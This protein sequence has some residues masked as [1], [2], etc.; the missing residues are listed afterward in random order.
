I[1]KGTFGEVYRVIRARDGK[2]S[3]AKTFIRPA[4]KRQLDEV[5]PV[6]LT[7]IRR[8]FTL[9][10]DNPHANVMQVFELRETPEAMIIMAYYPNGNIM[11]AGIV[12][13][14]KYIS[15]LGQILDGLSHIHAKR[16]EKFL[17]EQK[18]FFKVVI[19]DFGLAKL[20]TNATLLTTFCGSLKYLAPEVFPSFS[21]GHGPLVDVWCLGVIILE[22]IYGIPTPP[23]V[24]ALEKKETK[25]PPEKWFEWID[26]WS[27]T[28]L[29][30]LDD[31]DDGQ[32]V[33]ILHRMIEV[34]AMKRWHAKKC[35]AQGFKNGLF[36]RRAVDGLVVCA[37][38]PY[39]L[40]LPTVEGD[41][42]TKTPNAASYSPGTDPEATIILG[43]L[44]SGGG[45]VDLL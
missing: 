40:V 15:A 17:V 11:D 3:A 12:D 26:T 8:E 16:H 32:V 21:D 38:D 5:D 35:L 36:K 41:G 6:W 18:P 1:G 14:D 30:K 45:S 24:P 31:E 7:G 28:L 42:G 37:S 2:Y 27:T 44:W 20:V 4:N 39:D 19:T 29:D 25:V 33:E 22:W 10:K 34:E 43:N 9:M 13:E 23:T